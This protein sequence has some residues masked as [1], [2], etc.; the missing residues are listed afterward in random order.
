M[1]MSFSFPKLATAVADAALDPRSSDVAGK[2]EDL[3]RTLSES[4]RDR[5]LQVVA[6]AVQPIAVP[7]AGEVLGTVVRLL[8]RGSQW[9]VESIKSGVASEGLQATPKEIYNALGYL[10]RKGHVRRIGYGRYIVDGMEVVTSDE[11]GGEP[12]RYEGD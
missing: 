1:S 2:I 6:K 5:V 8:R 3:L 10:T 9:S 11:L 7:Q 4:Q 12:A